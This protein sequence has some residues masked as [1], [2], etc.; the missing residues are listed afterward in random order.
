MTNRVSGVMLPVLVGL[1]V[2]LG[3]PAAAQEQPGLTLYYYRDGQAVAVERPLALRGAAGA[4]A[5]AA[6][7]ALLAGPSPAERDAGLA[8]ALPA[9]AELAAVAVDGEEATVDLRLPLTFLRGE[10]EAAGSDAIVEQVVKT[11]HPLGLHRVQV[12]AADEG[13]AWQPLSSFFPRPEVPAPSLPENGEPLPA[14][15]APALEAAGQPP[16]GGQGR[17]RGA[18]TGKTVW[19]SGGHGW[20]WS[21]TLNRWTTQRGNNYGLVEDLSNAEAVN[22]YLARYLWNAGADVWMVRER[23]MSQAEVIVDNDAGSPAYSETGSWAVSSTP[24][25]NGGTYRWASTYSSQTSTAT[26]RP[27][28]PR[29]DWYA[30]WAWYLEGA[31]RPFDARYQ[32]QHAGGVTE[33]R[34]SQEVHGRTWRYLGEYYFESGTAGAVTLINASDETGQAVIADAVRFGGGMGSIAVGGGTSGRPRWEE[35]ATYWARYQGAPPEVVPNDVTARPLYA[36]WETARGYPGEAQNAVFVSWHTNAGGGTGSESYIHVSEPT[37]GS[38]QLQDWIH[39]ELI[40]DLRAGWDPEWRDRGQKAADFG[41]LREL[42]AIPG[43]LLEVAFHDSDDPGDAD[44]LREPI[45]RQVAA[46]AVA[47]GIVRYFAAR[48]GQPAQLAP[49]PPG[50]L[51][52]RN[53]S[54]G[55]VTLSWAPPPCCDGLVGDAA[56]G[57]KVYHSAN[58]RAF[59]NGRETTATSLAFEDLSP[60]SLHFFRVTALNAGGESF[61]TAVVAAR[62]PAG[63][64]G[65]PLLVVDGFDRLDQ[66]AMVPERIAIYPD[67]IVKRMFLEQMN[68]YSY[69][70]EHGQAL[71]ACDLAFDGALDEAVTAGDVAL[72]AYDALDWFTGEDS[73]ADASLDGA[74]RAL[75]A[76]YLDDGGGLLLSGAEIGYDL[77]ERGRDPGFFAGYLRAGYVGDS[78]GTYEFRGTGGTSFEGLAGRFDGGY[79]AASADLLAPGPGAREVLSYEGGEAGAAAIAYD[80]D[81]RLVYAG[82]PLETVADPAARDALVCRAAH[83]LLGAPPAAPGV[84][85][86]VNP[87]FEGGLA[88]AAWTADAAP[89]LPVLASRDAL[90]AGVEPHDGDW[91][92]W[93]G[94][95][96]AGVA[97]QAALAQTVA[98]PAG[99]PAVTLSLAWRVEP[100]AG[101]APGDSLAVGIYDLAGNLR[102]TALTLSAGSAPGAWQRAEFDLSPFA[103][104]VV[105]V[106]LRAASQGTAFFVDD[107]TVRSQGSPGPA[108]FRGLWVDAYH[109][110]FKTPQEIDELVET[111]RAGNLNALVVQ[112]RRRGDTYYPSGIDPWAPDALPGFDALAHLVARAH[113]A[114]LEVHA[115][116]P[117]LAIWGGSAPPAA[118]GHVYNLHGPGATG[119][120]YWLM[121]SDGG[122]IDAEGV[123]YLDPGHPAVADYLAAVVA[124][125]QAG[126]DLDGIHLDRLRYPG[127]DWGYNPTALARFQAD[128]GRDDVPSPGDAAWL[129]WRRDQVTALLRRLYLA[130]TAADPGVQV[131]VALS[132]AGAAPTSLATWQTSTPY[133]AHLQ[134]WR[135]WLEEGIL[136]LGL[137]MTYRDAETEAADLQAWITWQKDHQYGRGVVVGTGLYKN[138][139]EGSVAQWQ[140]VRQPSGAGYRAL[141]ACGY[142]YASPASVPATG[143]ELA[144]ALVEGVL[145]Q[146]APPPALAWKAA[147]AR[148]HLLGQLVGLEACTRAAGLRLV[149]E[150]PETRALAVDGGGWFGAVDLPPGEYTLAVQVDPPATSVRLPVQV[151]AGAVARLRLPVPGCAPYG[152]HVPLLYR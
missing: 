114:G 107:V 38:A 126:Y 86:L 25:Y 83:Y 135:A 115:W 82:F 136:D 73:T 75:L 54:P 46:R 85:R 128:T 88:Q 76:A 15:A 42:S 81:Y 22:Y 102:A 96:Q 68:S 146:W 61:P 51:V 117:A 66:A 35:Q 148:G 144:N 106:V 97:S 11:L 124:E 64:E 77:V 137:P 122:S 30:V 125:L 55:Q 110:G 133:A 145:D 40:A 50:R 56:A 108:E 33:V 6:L 17:P 113:A 59:D 37:P 2:L 130:A 99:E 63:T 149:L 127:Q 92:A 101:A 118:P 139:L 123:S 121:V 57:Y 52:A 45:F 90:P 20:Y 71:H 143:R 14:R 43:V 131:S 150:G 26:W 134:D 140:L 116:L 32:V 10:L 39:A 70:V 3:V 5:E 84:E 36:E 27:D 58:G 74:Q 105:Q 80:G 142:S 79:D 98:L 91:V 100:G 104:Q 109:P 16:A 41:E 67:P 119:D 9:G 7:R 87:G 152:L 24:G 28:L 44:D 147:P 12:R 111:A 132:A 138:T 53:T 47:Q 19:L 23:A 78:A 21:A 151:T 8:S 49:E 65:A 94:G 31:N 29:A 103:G 129:Q 69:A 93:L 60:G 13:G 34:L 4:D 18:L 48:D 120:D 72:G 112:V 89:G 95:Y 1:M 62:T 141:G